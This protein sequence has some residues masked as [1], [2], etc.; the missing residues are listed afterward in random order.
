MNHSGKKA[1]KMPNGLTAHILGLEDPLMKTVAA[2]CLRKDPLFAVLCL[3]W[4]VV[5]TVELLGENVHLVYYA[6]TASND[7]RGRGRW[8]RTALKRGYWGIL[9]KAR[10]TA[11]RKAAYGSEDT[12]ASLIHHAIIS[13]I[14]P[15]TCALV[16][17]TARG[18][19]P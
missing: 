15:S 3:N 7:M 1:I 10:Y 6:E 14:T 16:N 19:K 17:P 9:D 11:Y 18:E 13:R 4:F 5:A 8:V 12:T 2:A